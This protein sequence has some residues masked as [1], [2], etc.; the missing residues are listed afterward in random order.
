MDKTMTESAVLMAV[1]GV[2]EDDPSKMIDIIKATFHGI[3]RRLKQESNE[4]NI[5]ENA[6]YATGVLEDKN[7]SEGRRLNALKYIKQANE[8]RRSQ[9]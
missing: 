7:L 1:S 2:V 8:L 4:R 6:F 5:F 3:T 9:S